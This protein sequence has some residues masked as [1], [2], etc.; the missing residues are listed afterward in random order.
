MG[1]FEI[2]NGTSELFR[3]YPVDWDAYEVCRENEIVWT[4]SISPCL[5]ITIYDSIR[6]RG[7][8]AHITGWGL[9]EVRPENIVDTLLRAARLKTSDYTK[10][11]AAL[12]GESRS[13]M[14]R[15]ISKDPTKSSLVKKRLEELGIPLIGEDLGETPHGREIVLYGTGKVRVY[16]AIESGPAK[17][18]TQF[19]M[20]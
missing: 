7:A 5:G 6:K 20:E 8:L 19:S 16:R 18:A 1:D 10:L 15:S 14:A 11:E 17:A 9:E 4:T 13:E 2:I 3:H 12:A